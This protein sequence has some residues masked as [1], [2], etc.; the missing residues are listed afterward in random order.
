MYM[1]NGTDENVCLEFITLIIM[2]RTR[3]NYEALAYKID[4]I[5]Y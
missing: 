2:K 1:R 4:L 5:L 3:G